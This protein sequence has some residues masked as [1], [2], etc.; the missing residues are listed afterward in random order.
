M[1]TIINIFIIISLIA[2]FNTVKIK[3]VLTNK[4]SSKQIS[5]QTLSD[6][7]LTTDTQNTSTNSCPALPET[8]S[9]SSDTD[10]SPSTQDADDNIIYITFIEGSYEVYGYCE[11]ICGYED[12]PVLYTE[13]TKF[14][15]YGDIYRCQCGPY[16]SSWYDMETHE[17]LSLDIILGDYLFNSYI[18][19][20]GYDDSDCD[21]SALK[22]LLYRLINN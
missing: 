15:D 7:E 4:Y 21:C 1:K 9:A 5:D 12:E 18:N 13:V 10:S 8:Q 6:S 22:N 17:E 19:M 14:P 20:V 2:T 3:L 16:Y 11:N